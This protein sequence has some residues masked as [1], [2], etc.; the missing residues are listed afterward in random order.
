[1]SYLK[2]NTEHISTLMKVL[3][4]L[5]LLFAIHYCSQ[6]QNHP[7]S[8]KF[9]H[10]IEKDLA[11]GKIY[12]SRAALLS[13]LI[14]DYRGSTS[15][16]DVDVS[17][18]VDSLNLGGLSIQSA[19][20][21][22]VQSARNH[23]IVIISENHAKPQHR[24]FALDLITELAKIGYGHLGMETLSSYPDNTLADTM[25]HDRGYPLNHPITGTYTL[26]PQMGNIVRKALNFDYRLFPYER[27]TR[28]GE[29]G[30]EEV[31]ADNIAAY[32]ND[33]PEAKLVILCGFHH[34]I[35]SDLKK[36]SESLW[37]AS[38][39]KAKTGLDPLTIYQDNFTEKFIN[40]EHPLIRHV[41]VTTPSVF[42]DANSSLVAITPHVDVEV[43]HPRT[44]YNNG[45]PNWMYHNGQRQ[46]LEINKDGITDYPV[47]VAAFPIGETDSVPVDRIELK[48]Q[49]DNKV[50]VL[51][52]GK[53]RIEIYDGTDI[54]TIEQEV[55]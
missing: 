26:E 41:N 5:I 53:Y 23:R 16:S 9:S 29:K 31:Q 30:R 2:W 6:A 13:S 36:N 25:L 20:P 34:A 18:G 22:I 47:L 1:M 44:V 8:P 7:Y 19:L 38:Y 27:N 46:A 11:D 37:M 35:E 10:E 12:E 24:I 42:T 14:G 39:L 4:T 28:G 49:N 43:L 54:T 55:K 51:S 32:L 45:R 33:N 52:P 48:Y 50:L 17:W 15:Y 3:S 21:L 40:N